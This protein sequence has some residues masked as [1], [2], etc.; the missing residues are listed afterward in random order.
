M[1][2]TTKGSFIRVLAWQWRACLLFIGTGIIA[3]LAHEVL[4]YEHANLPSLPS[5]VVGAALGIF[6]SFRV[7]AAYARWWEGRVLWGRLVNASRTLSSQ[8]MAYLEDAAVARTVITRHALYVHVLRCQL[9]DDDPFADEHVKRIALKLGITEE[10]QAELKKQTS[11]CHALADMNLRALAKSGVEPLRLQAMDQSIA[12]L[13]DAQGGCERIKRTPMPRGYGFFVQRLTLIFSALFPFTIVGEVGWVAIPLN[14]V[15]CIG[16]TL[17]SETGRVLEDP[18]SHFWNSLPITNIS[19]NI[20]RN[21][22]QRLGDTDLPAATTP[23]A[24]GILY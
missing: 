16:F 8:V 12:A 20:E 1:M 6:A 7:N 23:D 22:R 5:T 9:R 15:V 19:L 18:F 14:L 13:V 3:F 4:A 11:M 17:I 24:Q 2:V 10:Q 21:V